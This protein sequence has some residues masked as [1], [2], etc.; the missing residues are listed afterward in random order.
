[1]KKVV[2]TLTVLALAFTGIA[3][4]KNI[5]TALSALKENNLD[6]AKESIDK[7]E[8]NPETKD[9]SKTL[10]AKGQI[11]FKLMESEKYKGASPWKEGAQA[12]IKLAETKP[13]YEKD[14]VNG[15][16]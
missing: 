4:Q 13:D 12:L 14:D 1:M 16:L 9:K 15:L 10:F 2:L 8:A 3:Q 7:A 5:E 11:Y 6:E